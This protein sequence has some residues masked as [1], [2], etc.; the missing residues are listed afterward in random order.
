MDVRAARPHALLPDW[1]HLFAGRATIT[2]VR[3]D[4][5]RCMHV[6]LRGG[7]Q[8]VVVVVGVFMVAVVAFICGGVG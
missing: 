6:A 1:R 2:D 4:A 7:V 8:M 5:G 3:I